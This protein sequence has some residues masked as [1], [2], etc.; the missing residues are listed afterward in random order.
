[1]WGTSSEGKSTSYKGIIT[2]VL[3]AASC[4]EITFHLFFSCPFS[5]QCWRHL[6]I[7]WRFDLDFHS[8]IEHAK[9]HHN[10]S[11]F[12]ETF[13]IRA[14]LIWM[15][16]KIGFLT[17]TI[18]KPTEWERI[19]DP[20]FLIFF[21]CTNNLLL[22]SVSFSRCHMSGSRGLDQCWWSAILEL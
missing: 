20:P 11:F 9:E 13:I 17:E 2:I 21:T 14:W 6:R 10:D 7:M 15:S 16:W 18:S 8:M 19:R 5:L 22:A 1:M 3:C 12:M 4:E